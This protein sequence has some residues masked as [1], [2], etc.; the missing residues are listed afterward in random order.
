MYKQCAWHGGDGVR[1]KLD[2]YDTPRHAIMSLLNHHV[3]K[4]PVLEPCAGY[5]SI[6]NILKSDGSVILHW[7]S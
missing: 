4:Y 6:A 5:G 3:I 2:H 1:S 7:R